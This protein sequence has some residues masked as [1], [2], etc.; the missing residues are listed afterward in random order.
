LYYKIIDMKN[1]KYTLRLIEASIKDIEIVGGKNASLGEMMQHLNKS[2]IN[3]PDGFI[4]TAAAYQYFIDYNKLNKKIKDIIDATDA[5]N[6]QQLIESGAKIRTLVQNGVFSPD[7][8]VEILE[9]YAQLSLQYEQE[10]ADVAVRSS[11]TA[12]DMPD[13]SFAGQQDTFLN[14]KGGEGLLTAV[15]N[16][17]A[18][19]FTDRA[20]SY[21]KR[22]GY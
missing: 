12:E 2:G 18:S 3:I 9:R 4:V 6:L 17:F 1:E 10:N 7:M 15:K 22:F 16:C 20:I 5:D 21:R 11:A 8:R 13:A 19:L 14:I